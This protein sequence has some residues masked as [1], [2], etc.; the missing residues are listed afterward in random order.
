MDQ[1]LSLSQQIA[2]STTR[3]DGASTASSPLE[4]APSEEEPESPA[5]SP[6][7]VS[8]SPA[9]PDP[10]AEGMSLIT[11]VILAVMAV[12]VPLATVVCDSHLPEASE[13]VRAEW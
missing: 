2:S 12:L 9:L 5:R 13:T 6:R 10:L 3:T 8:T 7:Q 11:G 1:T 4:T